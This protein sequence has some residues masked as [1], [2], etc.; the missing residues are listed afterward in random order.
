MISV[1]FEEYRQAFLNLVNGQPDAYRAI[2]SPDCRYVALSKSSFGNQERDL[3][4]HIESCMNIHPES[5]E[6]ERID[7][8]DDFQIKKG[9]W[10]GQFVS[11]YS[12]TLENGKMVSETYCR[13]PLS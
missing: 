10:I 11:S 5:V 4:S 7:R 9:I 2:C 13:G 8:G 3:E 6:V 12:Q 1:S